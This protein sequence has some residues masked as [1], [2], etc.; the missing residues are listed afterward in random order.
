MKA[1]ESIEKKR[2]KVLKKWWNIIKKIL[3][4]EGPNLRSISELIDDKLK[5]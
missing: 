5:S 3:T 1:H 4:W 2:E